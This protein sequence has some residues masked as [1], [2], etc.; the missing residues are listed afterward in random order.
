LRRAPI[1]A[2]KNRTKKRGQGIERRRE[3]QG[4]LKGKSKI[5]RRKQ[6]KF[7]AILNFII[8]IRGQV[9][10]EKREDIWLQ[11]EKG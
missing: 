5:R 11:E 10:E 7:P 9:K 4:F 6:S 2:I 1:F 8:C 3:R